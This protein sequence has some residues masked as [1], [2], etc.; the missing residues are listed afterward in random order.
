MS[1]GNTNATNATSEKTIH[2]NVAN[3]V[4]HDGGK[5]RMSLLPNGTLNAVMA[6]LEFGAT[7]Y[8]PNNWQ[9]VPNSRERYYNAAHRH[10]DAW[11]QGEQTDSESGQPHLAHAV[12]CLLFLMWFDVV[13]GER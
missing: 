3:G 4:K 10:I 8:A 2:A 7:K 5:W 6:V 9:H 12:C 13:D 1:N 11:W